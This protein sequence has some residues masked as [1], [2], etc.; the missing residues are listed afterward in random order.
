M[1]VTFTCFFLVHEVNIDV[2]NCCLTDYF[3][4]DLVW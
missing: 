2:R 1:P 4:K 3:Q